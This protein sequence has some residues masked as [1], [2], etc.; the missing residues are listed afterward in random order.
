MSTELQILTTDE[1]AELARCERLIHRGK[2][3]MLEAGRALARIRDGRLYRQE[4]ATFESYCESRWGWKRRNANYLIEAVGVVESLPEHL[5]TMVPNPRVAR[6]IAQV[7][8]ENR[9]AVVE[10]AAADGKPLTAARVQAAAEQHRQ[11]TEGTVPLTDWASGDAESPAPDQVP[12]PETEP[13]AFEPARQTTAMER[14]EQAIAI[15]RLIPA[16]DPERN[17]AFIRLSQ[18]LVSEEAL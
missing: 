17:L 2:L 12:A 13:P 3:S 11:E 18:W 10:R 9:T 16:D 14:A 7:P 5:G 4:H 8:E 1:S 6:E 15:M